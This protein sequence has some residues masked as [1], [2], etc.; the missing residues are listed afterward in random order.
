[1]DN[2]WDY[3]LLTHSDG[4]SIHNKAHDVNNLEVPLFS[5]HTFLEYL[6]HFIIADDQVRLKDFMLF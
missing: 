5:A 4:T 2:K 3:K 6:V 1:M